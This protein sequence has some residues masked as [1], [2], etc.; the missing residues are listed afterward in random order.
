MCCRP[1]AHRSSRSATSCRSP[2]SFGRGSTAKLPVPIRGAQ[3]VS[4]GRPRHR[5]RRT[6]SPSRRSS[7][8]SRI[9]TTRARRKRNWSTRMPSDLLEL[10]LEHQFDDA[11]QQRDAATMGMWLFLATEVL[12]FGAM[13]LGYTA[14]RFSYPQAFADASRHT[15]IAF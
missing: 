8:K 6:T 12:F 10:H 11:K 9:A 7:T 13:L 4:N 14:Y 5:R 3:P 15:L 1:P 2:T